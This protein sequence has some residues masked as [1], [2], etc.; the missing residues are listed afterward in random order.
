M[1]PLDSEGLHG[2]SSG[3]PLH[4]SWGWRS[5]LGLS[6]HVIVMLVAHTQGRY[7]L[8]EHQLAASLPQWAICAS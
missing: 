4:Q 6:A 1:V 2:D 5:I 3:N 7:T 8:P